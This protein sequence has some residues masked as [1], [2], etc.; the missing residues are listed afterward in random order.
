MLQAFFVRQ[1]IQPYLPYFKLSPDDKL[2]STFD[3]ISFELAS[4]FLRC[5]FNIE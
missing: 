5:L 4:M 3:A 2:I 1:K